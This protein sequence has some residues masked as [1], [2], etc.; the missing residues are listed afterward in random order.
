MKQALMILGVALAAFA[1]RV[2]LSPAAP[3]GAAERLVTALPTPP[4]SASEAEQTERDIALYTARA[5][6]DPLGAADRSKL[7]ELYLARARSTGNVRDAERAE[8]AARE[9][10]ALRDAH[11]S[12]TRQLLASSLLAQHRFVEALHVAGRLAASNPDVAT[13]RALFGECQLEVGDYAGADTTFQSLA[14]NAGSLAIAPRVA[15]WHELSGRTPAARR[16]LAWARDEAR[17]S[18]AGLTGEQRAWF[19]L[20]V[21][22]LDLRHRRLAAAESS[23]RAGLAANPGD[24]RVLGA[25]AR[26]ELARGNPR[27]AID[28]GEAAITVTLDP[29]TL[30]VLADAYAITGDSATVRQYVT[31][32]SAAVLQQP[33]AY[34][35]AWSL[36][37]L[38]HDLE[39]TRVS[40]KVREELRSRRD[41]YGLDLH[42]WALH[43]QGRHE[44]ASAVMRQVLARGIDD[45]MLAEHARKIAAAIE[46][47]S[48]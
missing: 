1:A 33:G 19:E 16:L 22:D 15:R 8:R 17:R 42:A 3:A 18:A 11:N 43:K 2:A 26:L 47:G 39:V 14:R 37:L 38:D 9:S 34:H 40:S 31:A 45:P 44:E 13:F 46:R 6:A 25:L 21:G 10:L 41:V 24:Y 4:M 27:A 36:W 29:A 7:A 30:G 28:A 32:L 48:R 23:F 12:R 35:R 5:A 20:R